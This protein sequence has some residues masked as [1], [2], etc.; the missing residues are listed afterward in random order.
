M[1]SEER[2]LGKVSQELS[3]LLYGS[4]A[5]LKNPMATNEGLIDCVVSSG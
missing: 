2:I 3:Q 5:G 1:A 4:I